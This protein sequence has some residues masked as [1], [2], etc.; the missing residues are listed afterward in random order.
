MFVLADVKGSSA[1]LE[2]AM[3]ELESMEAPGFWTGFISGA[4]IVSTLTGI[5]V[6]VAIAT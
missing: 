2:L 1:P 3:Q 5:G 4:G 6:S